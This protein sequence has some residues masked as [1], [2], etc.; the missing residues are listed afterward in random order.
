MPR[1]SELEHDTEPA[2]SPDET[3]PE[4]QR[5]ASR[6]KLMRFGVIAFLV[7][8]AGALYFW[9]SGHDR[10]STDDAQ[11]DG[12]IAPIS[13]KVSGSVLDVLVDINYNVHAGQLLVKL[14][15]SDY[16]AKVDQLKAAMAMAES[17]ANAAQ[18][19]VPLTRETTTS[20]T[21]GAAA[22]VAAAQAEYE[23][24]QVAARQAA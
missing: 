24:T 9:W 11:I 7:I 3:P 23:R 22:Q 2:H 16:Q 14:D 21:T 1:T 13:P 12:H 18:V 15:P 5:P 8:G 6:R 4:P 17:Q 10:E 20:G 19:G